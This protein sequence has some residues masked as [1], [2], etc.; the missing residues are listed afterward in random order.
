MASCR[1]RKKSPRVR[2]HRAPNGALRPVGDQFDGVLLLNVRKHRAPNGALRQII[3]PRL[4]AHVAGQKAPSTIRCIKTKRLPAP[5]CTARKSESIERQTV[6][7]DQRGREALPPGGSLRVRKHRA[8]KGTL[9]LS[10]W[11]SHS[12]YTRVR[13]H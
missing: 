8:P 12:S 7:E 4:S 3:E 11:Y 6:H 5:T 13:K 1:L 10:A 9:R 2:K